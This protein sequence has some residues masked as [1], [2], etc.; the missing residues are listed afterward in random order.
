MIRVVSYN[1][2]SRNLSF[3]FFDISVHILVQGG[4]GGPVCFEFAI[5]LLARSLCPRSPIPCPRKTASKANAAL[6]RESNTFIETDLT[7]MCSDEGSTDDC[8]R[9]NE[10]VI[11]YV[12]ALQCQRGGRSK[13]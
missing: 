1:E 8:T 6:E 12:R 7:A 13:R 11:E 5:S 4:E 2:R 9:C 10:E 3:D